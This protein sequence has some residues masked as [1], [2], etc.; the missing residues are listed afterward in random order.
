MTDEENEQDDEL[1]PERRASQAERDR[2]AAEVEEH[3]QELIDAGYTREGMKW[4]HPLD[5]DIWYMFDPL[6]HEAIFSA[7]RA[8][9]I[10]AELERAKRTGEL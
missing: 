1:T 8:A 7:K 9:Q 5:H 10:G 3:I 4:V 2:K 6:S